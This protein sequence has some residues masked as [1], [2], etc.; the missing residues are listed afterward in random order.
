MLKGK[1]WHNGG[2]QT[3]TSNRLVPNPAPELHGQLQQRTLDG[4]PPASLLLPPL[5]SC[6]K[7]LKQRG[8]QIKWI[9]TSVTTPLNTGL[10]S[11]GVRVTLLPWPSSLRKFWSQD[12]SMR[13][14]AQGR[15][16]D[17]A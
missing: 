14:E 10:S 6:I 12:P 4:A 2:H 7:N 15:L 8:I 11:H 17:M 3:R 5:S 1:A 13:E 9:L 16:L